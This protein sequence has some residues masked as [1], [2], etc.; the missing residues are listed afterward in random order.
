MQPGVSATVDVLAVAAAERFEELD[1]RPATSTALRPGAMPSRR[2]TMR[3]ESRRR[4]IESQAPEFFRLAKRT[5]GATTQ[6]SR[7]ARVDSAGD[8]V[9]VS[10]AALRR[11]PTSRVMVCS[12]ATHAIVLRRNANA[13]LL[14]SIAWRHAVDMPSMFRQVACSLHRLSLYA[15]D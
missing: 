14:P 11:M 12:L 10:V 5:S 13:N 8:T 15:L 9:P 2:S 7:A 1:A 4:A 3:S 6:V